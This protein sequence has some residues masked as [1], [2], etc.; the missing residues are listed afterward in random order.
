ME[1]SGDAAIRL[2]S[3][4]VRRNGTHLDL[5]RSRRPRLAHRIGAMHVERLRWY[6]SGRRVLVANV[7]GSRTS[8]GYGY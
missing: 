7:G 8:G 6:Q 1:D 4:V 2:Q 3:M 5:R